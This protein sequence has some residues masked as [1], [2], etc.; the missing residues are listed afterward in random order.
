[1]G[2]VSGRKGG[3]RNFPVS[4]A[5][6]I[7][8]DFLNNGFQIFVTI[9]LVEFTC[10]SESASVGTSPHD[11]DYA[12]LLYN[13]NAWNHVILIAVAGGDKSIVDRC[14]CLRVVC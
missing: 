11:L 5:A 7:I 4:V 2:I 14:R 12:V 10:M 13:G 6:E 8:F 9:W 1:M 3:E